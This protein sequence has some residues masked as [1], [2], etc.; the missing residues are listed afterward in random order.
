[1]PTK[2]F[3]SV[4]PPNRNMSQM[5]QPMQPPPQAG[6]PR[7]GAPFDSGMNQPPRQTNMASQRQSNAGPNVPPSG[8]EGARMGRSMRQP[9][10][11]NFTPS[12]NMSTSQFADGRPSTSQQRP[13]P[14]ANVPPPRQ[15]FSQPPP[16]SD[17]AFQQ[18]PSDW[19]NKASPSPIGQFSNSVRDP[20]R[21]GGTR[22]GSLAS[23]GQSQSPP[24]TAR[25]TATGPFGNNEQQY[26][27]GAA[28]PGDYQEVTVTDPRTGDR[29]TIRIPNPNQG[30][31]N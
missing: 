31:N 23:S 17:S 25:P 5:K 3:S 8:G 27:G 16:Q 24:G 30:G 15:N 1:M 2:G 4:S 12:R 26:S 21:A 13:Q 9:M 10:S 18:G 19:R 7:A 22:L 20:R 6:R 29:R 11:D 14:T 28:G